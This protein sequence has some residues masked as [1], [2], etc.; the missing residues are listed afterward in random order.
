MT[1]LP[2]M[3]MIRL[4]IFIIL[5]LMVRM[6]MTME[7]VMPAWTLFVLLT[8][9]AFETTTEMMTI[10]AARSDVAFICHG[11]FIFGESC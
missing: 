7:V 1:M 9:K 11:T 4:M 2:V 8:I 3:T 6:M 10:A 5:M